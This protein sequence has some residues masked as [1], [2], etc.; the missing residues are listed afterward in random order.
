[1]VYF[2]VN[3][4]IFITIIQLNTIYTIATIQSGYLP[5]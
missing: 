1:M 4:I 5:I 2:S 3:N